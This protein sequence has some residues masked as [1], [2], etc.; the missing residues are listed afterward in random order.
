MNDWR[1]DLLIR[2]GTVGAATLGAIL[3]LSGCDA[4]Y[5]EVEH[6]ERAKTFQSEGDWRSSAIELKNALRRNPDNA[7]ARWLLGQAYLE[8]GDGAAAEKELRRAVELGK[9]LNEALLPLARALFLQGR[10]DEMLHLIPVSPDL[11]PAARADLHVLRGRA[12]LTQ[13]KLDTAEAESR[14]ALEQDPNSAAARLGLALVASHREQW[15]LSRQ[16]CTQ[17]LEMAPKYPDAWNLLGD[18]ERQAGAA[19]KAEAAY[20]KA[21]EYDPTPAPALYK[22]ALVRLERQDYA[23][24]EADARTLA[25]LTPRRP[26]SDYVYGLIH[27]RQKRF[28]AAQTALEQALNK[29]RRFVPALYDLGLVH[30]AQDHLE[31]T[32]AYLNQFLTL[33]PQSHPALKLLARVKLRSNDFAQAAALLQRVLAAAPD[34]AEATM[35]LGSVYLAQGEADQG[36]QYFQ[37]VADSSPDRAQAQLWLGWSLLKQGEKDKGVEALEAAIQIEPQMRE[38]D[39]ILV[40]FHLQEKAFDEALEVA[41]QRVQRLPDDP[42][43]HDLLGMVYATKGENELAR[44]AFERALELDPG[45]VD[46]EMN[47]VRLDLRAGHAQAA[48]ARLRS[49]LEKD[50]GQPTAMLWLAALAQQAGRHDESLSWLKKAWT[51]DPESLEVGVALA[52]QY[53]ARNQRP[54]ALQVAQRLAAA[55]PDEPLAQRSLG[56]AL[57]AGG[58]TS[59][60]L[61][62]FRT[63]AERHPDSVEPWHWLAAAQAHAN[64]YQGALETLDKALA[65]N[66]DY[67]P[68]LAAKTDL[69]VHTGQFQAALEGAH[70]IQ[71]RHPSA[72]IGYK[73]EGDVHR[74]QGEASKAVAAYRTAFEKAPDRDLLLLLTRTQR[75][76][77][78]EQGAV[79]ALRQWLTVH[80]QDTEVQLQLVDRLQQADSPVETTP[81]ADQNAQSQASERTAPAA[82]LQLVREYL[83]Q[84]KHDLALATA[85]SLVEQ[86]P[87][88]PIAINLLGA[89]HMAR[90]ELQQARQTFERALEL[91]PDSMTARLNLAQLDQAEGDN[92]AAE[93][94][95]RKIL[96]L[97]R[98]HLEAL[99]NLAVLAG[100]GGRP[101]EALDWLEQAWQIHPESLRAG[102]A[103]TDQY[104][105]HQR[106]REAL[107]V[108]RALETRAPDNPL[109]LRLLGV[110]LLAV[111]DNAE[112]LARLQRL[113]E[114]APRFQQGW[115][116]LGLVQQR[117]GSTE[118]A[119][120]A[121]DKSLQIQPNFLPSLIAK[122]EVLQAAERFQEAE[123][124]AR[125]IQAEYASQPIGY[126]LEGD[127]HRQQQAYAKAVEAYQAAYDRLPGAELALL[128]AAAQHDA[129]DDEAALEALRRWL[130]VEP[131]DHRVHLELAVQLHRMGRRQDAVAEYEKLLERAPDSSLALNN[132]A[133]LYHQMGDPRAIEYAERAQ[134]L[135][136]DHPNT[137]GTLGW[138]LVQNDQAQQG[139]VYLRQALKQAPEAP[140]TRYYLAVAYAN[141]GQEGEARRALEI[142]LGDGEPFPERPEAEALLERLRQA[143]P[144]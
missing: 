131:M 94:R 44:S 79:D 99:L 35:L 19:D 38:A 118:A 68:A 139:L 122:V 7:E 107:T 53:L 2:I 56:Q 66:A 76:A 86:Y 55:H 129:G 26:E 95:Y 25:R 88:D 106:P 65:V 31:Q 58:D 21:I 8:T 52:Q 70:V 6:L 87:E 13:G 113:T 9:N 5:S 47:L 103:L 138:L 24:A 60:A 27:Y 81:S 57:L 130:K 11:E 117:L 17:A 123:A 89:V 127:L 116:L 90:S 14:Q 140:T 82:E 80:P 110:A 73:L 50:R 30:F 32:E 108:A 136:P 28:E 84:G 67:L 128:L 109:V 48:E 23:G 20:D 40:E 34:D 64:D 10:Q 134:R 83:E 39:P 18:L 142:L 42:M 96:S 72:A 59:G 61:T 85:S 124:V 125:A 22:R 143:S 126:K 69:Q 12:Y 115:H 92:A 4:G 1:L 141:T 101:K 112:A 111:G 100:Q 29:D 97:D 43:S 105:V 132:L 49:V 16:W 137:N 119:V 93:A 46:A 104:L 51:I 71:A 45:Y 98:S 63:L 102:L 77:G 37:K 41:R 144:P 114:L 91:D 120:A 74:R 54:D 121:L 78:D 62:T 15:D 133:W 36:V 135:A 3:L 33:T 75:E